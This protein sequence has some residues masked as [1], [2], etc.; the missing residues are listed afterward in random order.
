MRRLFFYCTLFATAL[1][2]AFL[3]A[4]CEKD[5]LPKDIP[6][7][8]VSVT[9]DG[10]AAKA[11][12]VERISPAEFEDKVAGNA[13]KLSVAYEV[14]LDGQCTDT[15]VDFS[16]WGAVPYYY[17]ESGSFMYEYRYLPSR[18]VT[19]YINRGDFSYGEENEVLFNGKMLFQILSVDETT[20]TTV[21]VYP[22]GAAFITG[23]SVFEKMSGEELQALQSNA[24]MCL[25][26]MNKIEFSYGTDCVVIS[27]TEFEFDLTAYTPP[28][29]F[30]TVRD[31]NCELTVDGAHV[32]GK[33]LASGAR[34]LATDFFITKDL[35]IVSN[36]EA[37][38]LDEDTP[39]YF[40]LENPVLVV[41]KEGDLY[42]HSGAKLDFESLFE[43]KINKDY[44]EE[45]MAEYWG[46]VYSFLITYADG[47]T[48]ILG[49]H[50]NLERY[51]AIITDDV[52]NSLTA[53][54]DGNSVILDIKGIAYDGRIIQSL[55]LQI[56]YDEDYQL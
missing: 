36:N 27:D 37:F 45:A 20:M 23:Y 7:I 24:L 48:K 53:G 21:E 11:V 13:W 14:N 6:L 46:T 33:L 12:D 44:Q 41:N 50:G 34:I 47:S 52:L 1:C 55:P 22:I 28:C 38:A 31:E 40:Y 18:E 3:F 4:G 5:N 39:E 56:I 16:M 9:D 51:S 25:D 26:N 15:E 2:G 35:L 19:G 8:E 43:A 17:F 29:K 32:K 10:L 42:S 54:G 49:K 30:T